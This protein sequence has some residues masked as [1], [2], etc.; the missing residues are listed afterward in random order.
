[1]ILGSNE[2]IFPKI[3]TL[4][5]RDFGSFNLGDTKANM[6]ISFQSNRSGGYEVSLINLTNSDWFSNLLD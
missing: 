2:P 5:M 6:Q 3:A 1:M 4:F